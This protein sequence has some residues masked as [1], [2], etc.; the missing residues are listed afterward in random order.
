MK[1]TFS[2]F[3]DTSK[4]AADLDWIINSPSLFIDPIGLN[5]SHLKGLTSLPTITSPYH[6]S[7][8]LGFYYQ[9]LWKQ[10]IEQSDQYELIAEELQI[11]S[12][13]RT[14]GAID[15]IVRD[16]TNQQLEHWEVAIKFYLYY[17]GEWLGPNNNDRLDLKI[18]KMLNHQLKMTTFEDF[19]QQFSDFDAIKP[20]MIVQGR[21]Y[22]N[23]FTTEEL[24][25]HCSSL[26]LNTQRIKGNWCFEHQFHLI[27]ERLYLLDKSQ[28][29]T[30]LKQSSILPFSMSK[31]SKTVHLQSQSGTY[32]FIV[33][34]DWINVS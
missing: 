29:V 27:K 28:W 23:P 10:V 14:V 32:W 5:A 9:W 1:P 8:R 7:N 2:L 17:Q 19:K 3:A 22:T 20:K 16:Q 13:G 30:G 18:G 33:P 11:N 15:F 4:Y 6:L 12:K 25:T 24:P 26:V 34:D 31:L 21:L